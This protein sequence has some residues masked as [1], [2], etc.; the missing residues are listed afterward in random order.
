MPTHSSVRLPTRHP[1][2]KA[3][4][5]HFQTIIQPCMWFMEKPSQFSVG[6]TSQ[7]LTCSIMEKPHTGLDSA[8]GMLKKIDVCFP[9]SRTKNSHIFPARP[10]IL[11]SCFRGSLI[12]AMAGPRATA[13]QSLSNDICVQFTSSSVEIIL[14]LV[15]ARSPLFGSLSHGVYGLSS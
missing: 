4:L 13:V 15:D 10:R 7:S 8:A 2:S 9:P 11:P 3:C 1:F 12:L 14:G 5:Q 6:Q